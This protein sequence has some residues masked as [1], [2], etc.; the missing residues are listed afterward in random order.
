M[1]PK[2]CYVYTIVYA[3]FNTFFLTA[4]LPYIFIFLSTFLATNMNRYGSVF[5]DNVNCTV[6]KNSNYFKTF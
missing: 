1:Q 3:N 6:N 4:F 2:L 5:I